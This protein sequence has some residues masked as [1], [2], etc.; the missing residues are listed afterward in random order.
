MLF[1]QMKTTGSFWI[2]AKFIAP[3]QS[4]SDVPPSPNH[5]PTTESEFLYLREYA[6]PAACRT[7]VPIGD[8]PVMMLNFLDPQW[9]GI[10]RPPD[11]GSSALPNNPR[12]TSR[13][14]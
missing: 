8:E 14:V 6:I 1:S 3:C 2:P 7:C 13:G 10:C 9:A 11:E 12:N 5:V 4:P